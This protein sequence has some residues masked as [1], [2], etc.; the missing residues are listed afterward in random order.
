MGV[1]HNS[2]GR[3]VITCTAVPVLWSLYFWG[4]TVAAGQPEWHIELVY[5]TKADQ[6]S[7]KINWM[8]QQVQ[9]AKILLIIETVL[10]KKQIKTAKGKDIPQPGIIWQMVLIQKKIV[11][12]PE[13]N[14]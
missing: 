11:Y 1:W 3:I 13:T 5:I 12:F 9:N 7:K 8:T 6:S 4:K 10:F 14:K 2:Y